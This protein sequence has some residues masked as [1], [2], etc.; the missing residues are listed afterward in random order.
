MVLV[1][2]LFRC[3]SDA[4]GD[5]YCRKNECLPSNLR[6]GDWRFQQTFSQKAFAFWLQEK[7]ILN[8]E[9]NQ[10]LP[11]VSDRK[12]LHFL[13]QETNILNYETN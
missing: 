3:N 12:L 6:G 10:I 5:Y 7:N 1:L 8:Y 13:F 11:I 2:F 9:T 4:K